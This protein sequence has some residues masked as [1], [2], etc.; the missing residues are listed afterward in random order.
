MYWASFFDTIRYNTFS[1]DIRYI[2][3]TISLNIFGEKDQKHRRTVMVHLYS[4]YAWDIL[5]CHWWWTV[6]FVFN[7]MLQLFRTQIT[8]VSIVL[9][10]RWILSNFFRFLLEAIFKFWTSS[11]TNRSAIFKPDI[12]LAYRK[13]NVSYI[14]WQT[15]TGTYQYI[16]SPLISTI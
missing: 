8:F 11:P 2:G 1:C 3:W 12:I 5:L 9:F 16:D 7:R 10:L 14:V 13:N 4:S 15:Y 6:I